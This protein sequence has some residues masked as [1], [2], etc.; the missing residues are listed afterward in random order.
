MPKTPEVSL[1]ESRKRVISIVLHGNQSERAL[2]N[3]AEEVRDEL[4]QKNGITLVELGLTRPFEISIEIPQ[5]EL[6]AHNLTIEQIAQTIRRTALELPAGEIKTLSGQI[7]LRTQERRDFGKEYEDIAITTSPDGTILRLGDIATIKDG[8]EDLDRTAQLDGK[9]AIKVNVFRV[10]DETPQSVARTAQEYISAK[11]A[12]LPDDVNLLIWEDRSVTYKQRVNLLLKNAAIGLVLVLILLGLFLEPRLAFWVTLGIPISV[13][14]C[15]FF[16]PWTGATINMISLFAFIVS[17]GII[18]D[19]AVVMGENIYEK[20]QKGVP[21]FRAAVEGAREVAS[22]VTFAVLT[23][24]VAFLPLF[25]VPGVSG[26]FY[27]QIPAIVVGVFI[28]SLIESLFILPAHLS[29][30]KPPGKIVKALDRPRKTFSKF[31]EN[32]IQ[33]KYLPFVDLVTR[34]RYV[35]CAIAIAVLLLAVGVVIGG[36]LKFSFMPKID[37]DFVTAQA[38]LPVGSPMETSKTIENRLI[39]SAESALKKSGEDSISKGIYSQIGTKSYW[40]WSRT[41]FC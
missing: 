2:R 40:F 3:L 22:P 14:G 15:F 13:L 27:R 7:L 11:R 8:F 35:A 4:L 30:N 39:N 9:P 31:L 5:R 26:K 37:A 32:F 12:A 34:F 19:D 18:V 38:I 1:I 24:I 17:L 41:V 36:R 25:F 20:R 33:T 6:R 21:A 10:G 28:V 16:V 23:N 29:H